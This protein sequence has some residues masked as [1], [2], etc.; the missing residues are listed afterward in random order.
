MSATELSPFLKESQALKSGPYSNNTDIRAQIIS[1]GKV[2]A[3][4]VVNILF[5]VSF[6]ESCDYKSHS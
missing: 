4:F 2:S 6:T 1:L 5:Y 3:H